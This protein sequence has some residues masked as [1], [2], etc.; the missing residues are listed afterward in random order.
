MRAV[1]AV[2]TRETMA[3][4]DALGRVV[5]TARDQIVTLKHAVRASTEGKL[6]STVQELASYVRS[7][8]VLIRDDL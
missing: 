4:A 1:N 2:T 8:T 6:S 7:Q 3:A 5:S